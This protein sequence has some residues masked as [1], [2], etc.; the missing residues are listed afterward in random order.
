MSHP[1]LTAIRHTC[2]S[3]N[4]KPSSTTVLYYQVPLILEKFLDQMGQSMK[5]CTLLLCHCL[6]WFHVGSTP[7]L[8]LGGPRSKTSAWRPTTMTEKC[9]RIPQS[10]QQ[11]DVGIYL[12]TYL[13]TPCSRVIL[14]KANQFSASQETPRILRDTKVHYHIHK[15]LPPVPILRSSHSISPGP[16]PSVRTF[17]IVIRFY[18]EELLAPRPIPKLEDHP[19]SAVSDCL[20]GIFAATLH[21]G[22]RSSIRNL[23]TPMPW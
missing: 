6:L 18:G 4:L 9:H 22:G 1:E 3:T 17:R 2:T 10:L 5:K 19:S 20:F 16:R 12:L 8:C 14:E 13:L 7:G 23:R 21:I 11:A 15:C